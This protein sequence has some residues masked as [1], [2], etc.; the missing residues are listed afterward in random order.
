MDW[1]KMLGQLDGM[2]AVRVLATFAITALLIPLCLPLAQKLGLYDLPGG[3]KQHEQPTPYIGGALILVAVAAGLFLFERDLSHANIVFCFCA[4]VLVV[5][6]LLDDRYDLSWR[7][8][9]AV[10]VLATL[11][12]VYFADIRVQNLD[13]VFGVDKMYLGWLAVPF[14]V[15]I[16]VGVINALNMIDGSDGLAAGQVMVSLLLFAGFALYAGNGPVAERL[17]AIAGA[18]AGFLIWNLRL[19]WQSRARVFL[20]NAGSMLLGFVIAL[21]AVRLTQNSA[22][23]VSPVLG[24]WTVAIPLL[25]C[26]VLM[27]RRARQGR[28]PFSADRNHLHHYL[29]DAGYSA[30]QVAWGLAGLSL[31]LGSTAAIAV[32]LGV[33]RPYV[34]LAF[35]VLL[36]VHYAF[37]A[38]RD[39][40]VAWLAR[41]RQRLL[42]IKPDPE[43][44]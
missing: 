30:N 3:R 32:K 37:S 8:R 15:F 7:L 38:D 28:S 12:M 25:D 41:G 6:G 29:L 23:P 40:A 42:S 4:L 5:V 33:H 16:V 14:T 1:L 20:G 36:G 43:A 31:I 26:V 9:I 21:S 18:V 34:V 13:D 19:P 39:R 27:F 35:F 22:H 10:Q 44:A 17:L 11:A 24:P 2:S